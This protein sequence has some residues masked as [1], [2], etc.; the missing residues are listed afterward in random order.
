MYPEAQEAPSPPSTSAAL[1]AVH[2]RPQ[3]PLLVRT[4]QLAT[5]GSHRGEFLIDRLRDS[6]QLSPALLTQ[7]PFTKTASPASS[8]CRRPAAAQLQSRRTAA[9]AV[10]RPD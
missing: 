8:E 10:Q 5:G 6:E 4:S 3:Q 9:R 1:P 7:K 2:R